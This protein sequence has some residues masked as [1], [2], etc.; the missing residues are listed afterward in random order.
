M[1]KIPHTIL[2][3]FFMSTLFMSTTHATCF[4][5][6]ALDGLG[7][8]ETYTETYTVKTCSKGYRKLKKLMKSEARSHCRDTQNS[9]RIDPLSCK[10]FKKKH[11]TKRKRP[12]HSTTVTVTVK[13]A[14][15]CR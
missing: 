15:D 3:A 14:A 2:S 8:S 1:K 11:C 13:L 6:T 12:G 10:H 9:P 7:Y 5:S 4:V